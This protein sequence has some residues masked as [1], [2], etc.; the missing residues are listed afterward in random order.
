MVENNQLM[1]DEKYN[2]M[3]NYFKHSL[4]IPSMQKFI[5]RV[6]T[7][8]IRISIA[9]NDKDAQWIKV[10]NANGFSIGNNMHRAYNLQIIGDEKGMI[11]AFNVIQDPTDFKALIPSIEKLKEVIDILGV[12]LVCDNGYHTLENIEIL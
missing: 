1:S 7:R 4:K 6:L 3:K 11:L 9:Y 12:T 10:K 5:K 8:S 2:V